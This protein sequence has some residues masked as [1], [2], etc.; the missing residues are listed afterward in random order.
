[1]ARNRALERLNLLKK[2]SERTGKQINVDAVTNNGD[3]GDNDGAIQAIELGVPLSEVNTGLNKIEE[4]SKRRNPVRIERT[5]LN[6]DE[7]INKSYAKAFDSNSSKGLFSDDDDDDDIT[8]KPSSMS[9]KIEEEEKNK[10]NLYE[11]L[12]KRISDIDCSKNINFVYE[13][14]DNILKSLSDCSNEDLTNSQVVILVSTMI[15]KIEEMNQYSYPEIE[16]DSVKNKLNTE[17]SR[18]ISSGNVRNFLFESFYKYYTQVELKQFTNLTDKYVDKLDDF[19][20]FQ[21]KKSDMLVILLKW[22]LD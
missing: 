20:E 16:L 11:E 1:M 8:F 9:K 7:E 14:L 3:S 22:L 17:G 5:R 15:T 4:S 19:S 2:Y 10:I 6:I 18:A 12:K 13:Q 21:K